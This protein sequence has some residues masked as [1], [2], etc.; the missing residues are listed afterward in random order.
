M[1][2]PH[3]LRVYSGSTQ[4]A[5]VHHT[6]LGELVMYSACTQAVLT[7]QLVVGLGSALAA[8]RRSYDDGGQHDDDVD[9]EHDPE[10]TRAARLQRHQTALHRREGR[11]VCGGS[12]N[13]YMNQSINTSIHQSINTSIN[14]YIN[15][16]IN[17]SVTD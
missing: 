3:I 7:G 17:Q 12:I 14:Q 9:D 15:Q 8:Q 10:E 2:T 16:Y 4:G 6:I 13:Q 5:P 11:R 1:C